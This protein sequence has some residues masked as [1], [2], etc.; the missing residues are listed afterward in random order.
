MKSFPKNVNPTNEKKF[1]KD[2]HTSS[3]PKIIADWESKGRMYL[4]IKL[5]VAINNLP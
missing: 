1:S 4:K 2:E 5:C 3:A